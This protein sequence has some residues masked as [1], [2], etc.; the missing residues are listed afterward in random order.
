MQTQ[1]LN[2]PDVSCGHCER[3][4]RKA[5]QPIPGLAQVEVEIPQRQVKVKFDESLVDIQTIRKVLEREGYPVESKTAKPLK[6]VGGG[7]CCG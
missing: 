6:K 3:T 7:C 4:I 5:L 1:I 2:V